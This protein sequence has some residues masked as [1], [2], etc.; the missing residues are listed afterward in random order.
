MGNFSNNVFKCIYNL[1]NV[2]FVNNRE[3]VICNNYRNNYRY[4]KDRFGLIHYPNYLFMFP[5]LCSKELLIEEIIKNIFIENEN[6]KKE[7]IENF[8]KC[9]NNYLI[10]YYFKKII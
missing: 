10:N 7:I 5:I 2:K 8:K 3:Y 6:K 1:G 4:N 9:N